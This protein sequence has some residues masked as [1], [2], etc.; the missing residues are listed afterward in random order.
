[1]ADFGVVPQIKYML[2]QVFSY[3]I[4]DHICATDSDGLFI[5]DVKS[6]DV[7]TFEEENIFSVSVVN[8]NL[9]YATYNGNPANMNRSGLE[10]FDLEKAVTQKVM[11]RVFI[12]E[13]S[14]NSQAALYANQ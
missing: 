6:R 13:F 11:Q 8:Q 7:Y 3:D 2:Q 5:I 4:N 14:P 1:M 10:I 9:V 12:K